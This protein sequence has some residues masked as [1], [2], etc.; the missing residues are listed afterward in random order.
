MAPK[1]KPAGGHSIRQQRKST[2]VTVPRSKDR[3]KAGESRTINVWDPSAHNGRRGDHNN[4]PAVRVRRS[5]R[6]AKAHTPGNVKPKQ[7]T[8]RG[9]KTATAKRTRTPVGNKMHRKKG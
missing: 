3:V 7:A 6:G 4:S 9:G 8:P 5:S 2:I 1:K